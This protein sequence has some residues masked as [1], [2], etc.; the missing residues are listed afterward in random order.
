MKALARSFVLV[1][2]V[3]AS[4]PAMGQWS[5]ATLSEARGALA[6]TTVGDKAMFAGGI[7]S[8]V[9][10]HDVVDIYDD[11]T[12][13]WSTATLS[14][15]RWGVAAT[16]VGTK[17]MFAGGGGGGVDFDVIDIYD[18]ATGMW[19]TATLSEA[20]YLLAATTVG[21]KAM[22]VGGNRSSPGSSDVVDIYDDSL[23][24]P[25][26]DPAAWS[27]AALSQARSKLAATT[28]GTKAMFAGG[29]ESSWFPVYAVVDIY[30]NATGIWSTTALSEARSGL[31]ATT[32]GTKAVFGGGSLALATTVV[33][34]YDDSLGTWSTASLSQEFCQP[35]ATTVGTKAIFGGAGC[36]PSYIVDIYDD[37]TGTWST[38]TLV[39]AWPWAAA[40]TVGTKALIGGGFWSYGTRWMSTNVVHIYDDAIGTIYCSPGVANSTGSPATI[41]SQGFP[42]SVAQGY[43]ILT[44][45]QV[46]P[47]EF[48]YCLTS[49]TPSFPFIPPGSS[50]YVCLGG[51]IGRYNGNVGQGPSFSLQIDLTNMPVNPPVGV[52]PGETWG[53]QAWYRDVGNSNNFTDAVAVTFQ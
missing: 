23:G 7:S 38:D 53:F 3:V 37:T 16:T 25:P 47:G 4:A 9:V 1:L 30:D 52:Q 42:G 13:T 5:T 22:F 28:V 18:D 36:F 8:F 39:E 14:E 51:N 27:T 31:A 43:A 49:M 2:A 45:N 20:R 41:V 29:N 48:G 10:A 21:T 50:G 34:I 40:T 6:V 33:D 26:S 44:A 11:S 19:S 46:P 17:A 32:V 35:V 12:G 24:L 15:A